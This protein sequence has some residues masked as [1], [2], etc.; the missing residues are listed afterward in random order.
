MRQPKPNLTLKQLTIPLIVEDDEN[1]IDWSRKS[2][3]KH[4]EDGIETVDDD[5]ILVLPRQKKEKRSKKRRHLVMDEK[6]GRMIVK[7]LRKRSRYDEWLE[8]DYD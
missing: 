6:S 7:R 8:D 1:R 2:L 5:E 3:R 4:Y